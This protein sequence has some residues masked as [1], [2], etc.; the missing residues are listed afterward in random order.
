MGT[1][2]DI[3]RKGR[4]AEKNLFDVYRKAEIATFTSGYKLFQSLVNSI[5]MY[6][7]TMWGTTTPQIEKFLIYQN[8]FLRKLFCLLNKTPAWFLRLE[9]NVK[10]IQVVYVNRLL[11]FWLRIPEILNCSDDILVKDCR[12]ILNIIGRGG[13]SIHK[14]GATTSEPTT[15]QFIGPFPVADNPIMIVPFFYLKPLTPSPTL[16]AAMRLSSLNAAVIIQSPQSFSRRRSDGDA[17]NAL[18]ETST[19]QSNAVGETVKLYANTGAKKVC[20]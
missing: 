18:V 5:I 13:E 9:T 8:K 4:I 19:V 16:N 12:K 14:F 11:K 17:P 10:T 2:N 20:K 1:C 7:S 15:E 3:F 6:R